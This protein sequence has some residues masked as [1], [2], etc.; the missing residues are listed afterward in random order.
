MKN[1]FITVFAILLCGIVM[2]NNPTDTIPGVRNLR[3]V[4]ICKDSMFYSSFPSIVKRPGGEL[5]VAFRRAPDRR[6]FGEP[7]NKHVDDNSYL[8]AV[9]SEDGVNWTENPDLIYAHPFGGSQDPCLLQLK[10]GTLLCTSYG[11]QQVRDSGLHNLKQP[12][13]EGGEIGRA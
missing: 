3:N 6:V 1:I 13:F 2:A 11:W 8:V 5:I 12:Y 7:G 10:D 9:R 4:V